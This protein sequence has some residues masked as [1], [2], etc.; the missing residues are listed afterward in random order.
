MPSA[1]A[2]SRQL[3]E[4][5]IVFFKMGD[6]AKYMNKQKMKNIDYSENNYVFEESKDRIFCTS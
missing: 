3:R 4:F 6:T 1:R 2:S 5:T